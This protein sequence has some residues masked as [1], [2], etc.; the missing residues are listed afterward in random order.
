MPKSLIDE[1]LD[2]PI[3]AMAIGLLGAIAIHTIFKNEKKHERTLACFL[4]NLP[5]KQGKPVLISNVVKRV[6]E[7]QGK[8]MNH[9]QVTKAVRILQGNGGLLRDSNDHIWLTAIGE[10]TRRH[11]DFKKYHQHFVQ[12]KKLSV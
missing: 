9:V 4:N 8:K 1:V 12:N 7:C 6:E 10:N 5:A 3:Q 2:H 11:P